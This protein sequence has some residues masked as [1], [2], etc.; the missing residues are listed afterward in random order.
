MGSRSPSRSGTSI[1]PSRESFAIVLATEDD[2]FSAAALSN[3][4][5][6]HGVAVSAPDALISAQAI[7]HGAKLLSSDADFARV[8]KFAP[9]DLLGW[10]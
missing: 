1:V 5:A 10:E 7:V 8:A 4:A 2:H 3:K 9:L 6:A